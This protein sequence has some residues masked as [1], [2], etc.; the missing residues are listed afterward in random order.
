MSSKPLCPCCFQAYSSSILSGETKQ[1]DSADPSSSSFFQ[2][3]GTCAPSDIERALAA[4]ASK[5]DPNVPP[6]VW[7]LTPKE[8]EEES[9]KI[10]DATKA[11][12]DAIAA[13]P[14]DQV[15][16]ENT[17][18]KLMTP[19]NYKT[20]PAVA[21]CK[22]LQHCSTDPAI[23]EQA[24]KAGKDFSAS[25]VQGRMRKDVYERV[26]AFSQT[27]EANS[28]NEYQQH[29]VKASLE[30]FERAGLALSSDDGQKL[31][32]L[33]EKDAAVCSEY[34]KNLG[35][36]STKLF[37]SPEELKGVGDD[38]TQERL[39]KDQEG[40]CTITLKY[41]DIIPI[42]QNCEVAETRRLVAEAR[43]GVNAYK[44]NLDLVAEG[45]ALRKQIATLL[46]YPS[47]AEYICSKRMSGS[48]QAV[49]DFLN[50]LETQLNETGK[51]NKDTLLALKKAHCEESG[52]QFDGK[53]NAWDT[54]FYGNRL[55]KVKYGVDAEA[56]K[57]YFPLDHVVETT[58]GIYQEL[59]G[60]T[61]SELPKGTFWSWYPEVRCF[62]VKDKATSERIGHFYL[63]LHPRQG[64]YGHAAIFHLVK[65]NVNQ[66]AVDCMLCNLPPSTK[67]KP[68]LLRHQNVVTFFHEFGHIM[69]GLCSVGVGNSTRLA[70]CPRD[71]VEAPSQM[72]VSRMRLRYR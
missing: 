6:I 20:N 62:D 3:C 17:V 42:G 61:F 45:I 25:R 11:N 21:A 43:E 63:D 44:N 16:F 4:K 53:L 9:Q 24:S 56:I 5:S 54:G 60:L 15:T 14:L 51:E 26:K 28:L 2:F 58:L 48:F 70:K 67:D 37:F 64:K 36:D 12:L 59:L 65:H 34:S 68:S 39:G 38:F 35:A 46:G 47:W 19:P 41:P 71:F 18:A 32:E 27:E 40:K 57:E 22:F 69:H 7:L 49:D 50:N 66:G 72:L 1:P 10:L 13:T 23:R 30:D 33:L 52:T 8:I 31:K 29:F 55:L